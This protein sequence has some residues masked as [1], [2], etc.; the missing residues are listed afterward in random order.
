MRRVLILSILMFAAGNAA[1]EIYSYTNSDGDYVV[2]QQKP[3]DPNISYAVLTDE[4][5]FV[6]MV[7]GRNKQIPISHWRPFFLPKEPHPFDGPEVDIEVRESQPVISIDEVA[8]AEE[9]D[10]GS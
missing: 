4:G 10:E 2:T 6:R 8:G 5:D 9:T 7:E 1:A 3:D